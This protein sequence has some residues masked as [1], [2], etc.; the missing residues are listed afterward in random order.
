MDGVPVMCSGSMLQNTVYK[1][2]WVYNLHIVCGQFC[3]LCDQHF[4]LSY[5]VFCTLV[6][7]THVIHDSLCDPCTDLHDWTSSHIMSLNWWT[8]CYTGPIC[9]T[10]GSTVGEGLC[11]RSERR[12]LPTLSLSCSIC[13]SDFQ[14]VPI[15]KAWY[16]PV[17]N[18]FYFILWVCK[19]C[20]GAL[21]CSIVVF[22]FFSFPS[23]LCT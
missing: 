3:F 12:E 19:T 8:I 23:N 18:S 20:P 21:T 17:L 4:H 7:E 2:Y 16:W 6:S 14:A 5:E 1:D 11:C 22:E 10:D 9:N 13:S 15:V